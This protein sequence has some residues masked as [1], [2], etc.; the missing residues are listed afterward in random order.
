MFIQ[1]ET[2]LGIDWWNNIAVCLKAE[3]STFVLGGKLT[4]EKI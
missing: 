2:V 3:N 1:K 4:P